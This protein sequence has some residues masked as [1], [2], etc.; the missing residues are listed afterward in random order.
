MNKKL[1][2]YVIDLVEILNKQQKQVFW[3]IFVDY[4]IYTSLAFLF[5]QLMIGF[6][7]LNASIS[8][9]SKITDF[10]KIFFGVTASSILSYSICYAFLPL[11]SIR[12][13]VLFILLSTFLILLPRITWQ[14]IYSKRK[15]GS[16]DGE[17][18]R[19]FLIGAGDG[20]ALFM[21]SYQHP[22]SELELVGILDKDAKKKG[23]KLG[24]I[25]VLGSYDNLP[26]LA[27]RHQIERVIVAIPSLDPSEYERIL[28]MCN[29]LGVKCYKMPKVETVVQ[30]LH[31]TDLL[32]R[33]EIRLDES[34]L[35][36]ELTGKTILVTGAGGSIGSEI[37]RQ[38]SRFN[39]ERIV[40]LGH[41]EN[42]IYLVYH[43]LIRKFQGIDYVPV[44]ADIQ[45]YDRLLQVFEQYK[46]AI[47]YHAAAH[48]HV[49][50]ME[51]NPKEAFKN[52]IRGTYNVAKAVDEAKVPKMVMISTDKAV[53]PPNVMGATKRVAELKLA[54]WLS[55]LVLMPRME[56]S[57]S[58]I[59]ANQSR[60]M[61]W[62]RK[63]S[64]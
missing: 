56:K 16:G 4:I 64:F 24:G 62:L 7:G 10:M 26:E 14:L 58:L 11:F 9:Y 41:G 8:R 45:D 52:N 22:T 49:P 15:K 19:T 54:V 27:K 59:W 43:E 12:F 28:Q 34:R 57:L 5:Y 46:P 48:K 39:P 6:W 21:D 53:N 63:W 33:Q 50:M 55:M 2:D 36:A 61:T 17:H 47:V 30:G 37:C 31:I 35:G 32:G 42:S 51:R 3:G 1:T 38:V 40:L 44:I 25:P 29:K 18:R 20:G 13:I 23:Q 60:F